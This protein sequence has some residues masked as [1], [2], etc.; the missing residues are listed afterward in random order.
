MKQ[1]EHRR[2]LWQLPRQ[3][4]VVGVLITMAEPMT[5][6]S[7][8]RIAIN[9][10]SQYRPV[11]AENFLSNLNSTISSLRQQ[12]SISRFAAARG[13]LNG[14][15]VYG[16]AWCRGY[17]SIP[18]CL[19]C[20]NNGVT[21]LNRCGVS[22]GAHG[23]YND[24]DVRYENY[25]FFTEFNQLDQNLLCVN[26]TSAKPTEF[27]RTAERLIS[28]LQIAASRTSNLY[29]VSTRKLET[30]G[31]AMVYG[32]AQCHL[33]L[34][35][36]SCLQC[37]K[38]RSKSLYDC[39]PRTSSWAIDY[40]C[41]MRY[42]ATPLFGHNQTSDLTSLLWDVYIWLGTSKNTS[43]CKQDMSTGSTE[44]LQGP[45]SYSYNDL[46]AATDNF[47]EENKLGGVFVEV[48]KGTLMDGCV[49]AIQKTFM[50]S[51]RGKKQFDDKLKI[52]S[53]IHQRHLLRI[54]GYC[55]KGTQLFLVHEYMENG[56]LDHFLFGEKT[57]I[58]NWKQR[59]EIIFGIARGLSYLHEQYHVPIIHTDIRTSNILLDSEFQPKIANFGLI[60]LLP[61]DKTH[62]STK[63]SGSLN[64]G[65]VAP[66]Y[67]IYGQLSE[68]VDTYSFG[69]VV[70]EIISGKRC[71]DVDYQLVTQNLLDHAWDLHESGMHLNLMDE[72]LDPSEYAVEHVVEIIKIA[73]MCTQPPSTRPAM[74]EVV[75]LLSEKSL[76]E[77]APILPTILDDQAEIE[78]A[79]MESI[80]TNATASTFQLSGC[81]SSSSALTVLLPYR[82]QSRK[83][84]TPQLWTKQF[85]RV[86]EFRSWSYLS[87][88]IRH[89]FLIY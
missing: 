15:P 43:R 40:G 19:N 1:D 74:S 88:F 83:L 86:L 53:N 77:R 75:M 89:K 59:F 46:K 64:S 13:L 38:W 60:R 30:V 71:K 87:I 47:S 66:E 61:E 21:Q 67:A 85:G 11:D 79:T 63:C 70:L 10:C 54:L 14:A 49:V 78:L 26:K 51:S 45:A 81:V 9:Y 27:Q 57:R 7:P 29:A 56:S 2:L 23:F 65:Y 3:L 24:C 37:L 52:I 69:V 80:A 20:F 18:D 58:L 84:Q 41:F 82:R 33:N 62:L 36:S 48:Y 6:Q 39:L 22:N 73:L 17:V 55:T 16:L 4:I 72:K 31:N 50:A 68:K 34:S 76:Q 25:N 42:S 35:R 8:E 5:S 44:L 32:I 28:D 12:L